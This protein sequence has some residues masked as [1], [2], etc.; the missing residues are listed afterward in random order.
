M[1]LLVKMAG[2]RSPEKPVLPGAFDPIAQ[3]WVPDL[4]AASGDTGM[5]LT[6]SSSTQ[7]PDDQDDDDQEMDPDNE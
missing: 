3:S 5:R 7:Q 1:N 4:V 2:Q 6:W